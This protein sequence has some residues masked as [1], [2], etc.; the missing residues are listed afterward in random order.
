M[1]LSAHQT[2]PTPSQMVRCSTASVRSSPTRAACSARH[3]QRASRLAP[4]GSGEN[5]TRRNRLRTQRVHSKPAFSRW[6]R[7]DGIGRSATSLG[8]RFFKVRSW[9]I[10]A[11]YTYEQSERE[12]PQVRSPMISSELS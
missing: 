4:T 11:T 5:K 1:C 7:E 3:S 6:R 2:G 10:S 9:T 12:P 8:A